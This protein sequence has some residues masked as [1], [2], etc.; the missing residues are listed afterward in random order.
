MSSA[1]PS[2]SDCCSACSGISV[3]VITSQVLQVYTGSGDPNTGNVEPDDLTIA[4]VYYNVAVPGE[5]WYWDVN[6]HNWF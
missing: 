5:I 6:A 3:S 2:V 1:L 4:N